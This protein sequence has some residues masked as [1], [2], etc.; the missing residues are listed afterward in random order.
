MVWEDIEFDA[1]KV[2]GIK[3]ALHIAQIV[4]AVIAWVL[5]I[6]VFR[7]EGSVINGNVGWTFA[8]FFLSIPAWIYLIGAPRAPRTRHLAEPH[9]M[10]GVDSIYTIIWLSAF[11]TQAAYNT[12]NLCGTACGQSKAIVGLGFFVCLFF[13]GSTFFS[14]YSLK[15]YQFHGKLPGYDRIGG[16]GTS[17]NIDPDKAAFSMAPHG[18]DAYAPIHGDDHDQHHPLDP[19]RDDIET[20]PG[21]YSSTSYGGAASQQQSYSS[22]HGRTGSAYGG[23]TA[24]PYNDDSYGRQPQPVAGQ[25]NPFEQGRRENSP[26]GDHAGYTPPVGGPSPG[27]GALGPSGQSM[28]APPAAAHDPYDDRPAQ[29]PAA[30]YDRTMH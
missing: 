28:Y 15:Y 17:Q 25:A 26:F 13:A 9:V 7:A 23:R 18:D 6:I 2:P 11:S 14:I 29:F 24:S 16:G 27:P 21:A 20:G 5:E 4:F 8:V 22:G 19:G 3:L 30:P 1:D 10:I 12:A